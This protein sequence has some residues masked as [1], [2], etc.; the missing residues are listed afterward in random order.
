[1]TVD[2]SAALEKFSMEWMHTVEGNIKPGRTVRRGAEGQ[3]SSSP[4]QVQR[5]SICGRARS[6]ARFRSP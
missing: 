1:V 6:A 3:T 5:S 4:F 2:L